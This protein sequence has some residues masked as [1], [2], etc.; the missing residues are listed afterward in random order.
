MQQDLRCTT[1]YNIFVS[2]RFN[3]RIADNNNLLVSMKRHGF[4]K[5]CAINCRDIGNGRYEIVQ[6]AHRLDCARKLKIPVWYIIDNDSKGVGLADFESSSRSWT[7]KDYFCHRISLGDKECLRLKEVADE[8]GV[9][10]SVAASL[11]MGE[12]A[13]SSNAVRKIK[14]GAFKFSENQDHAESVYSVIRVC[15]NASIECAS[16]V[17]FICAISL[18]LLTR[19]VNEERLKNAIAKHSGMIKR[20]STRDGYLEDLERAYNFATKHDRMPL[21]YAAIEQAKERQKSVLG[22]GRN[23]P[24]LK[25][26]KTS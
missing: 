24:F 21:K 10:L 23:N 20:H 4:I 17:V 7:V 26:K 18:S 6:G 5:G 9:G 1:D 12:G 25:K 13:G 19:G 14:N 3:R 16:H 2:N 15:K 22:N 8:N 11:A